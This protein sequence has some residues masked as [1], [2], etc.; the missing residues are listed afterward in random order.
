MQ[1]PT[2]T[3]VSNQPHAAARQRATQRAAAAAARATATQG[4]AA[5]LRAWGMPPLGAG[6]AQHSG[7]GKRPPLRSQRTRVLASLAAVPGYTN[8]RQVHGGPAPR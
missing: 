7:R 3:Q 8:P 5:A 4:Q 1:Q 2:T 6:P